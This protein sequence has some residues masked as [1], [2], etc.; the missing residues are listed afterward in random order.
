MEEENKQEATITIKKDALWKYSTL[1][2]LA[3]V[4]IGGFVFFTGDNSVNTATG[5]VVAPTQQP[6]APSQVKASADDDPVLGDK[7]AQW[8]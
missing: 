5:N 6:T 4:V 8:K 1:L 2:L 7:N 3:I